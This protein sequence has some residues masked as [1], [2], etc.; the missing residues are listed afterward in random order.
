[1]S[2]TGKTIIKEVDLDKA[3]SNSLFDDL[4]IS[5]V[6]VSEEELENGSASERGLS[7]KD[8]EGFR[9]KF[10]FWCQSGDTIFIWRYI[11]LKEHE[12]PV[13]DCKSG[14]MESAS[15]VQEDKMINRVKQ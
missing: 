9:K 11:L 1:L 2:K 12:K 3:D 6:S 5:N 13:V 10:Y 4:E 15:F 7:V 8:K 14:H